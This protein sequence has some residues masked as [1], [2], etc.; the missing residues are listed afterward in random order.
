MTNM[1]MKNV[2]LIMYLVLKFCVDVS[3]TTLTLQHFAIVMDAQHALT[4]LLEICDVQM[5]HT[6]Q[7]HADSDYML[8]CAR[9]TIDESAS[10]RRRE[11]GDWGCAG[12]VLL[13]L[14]HL[15]QTM[16]SSRSLFQ[17]FHHLQL[18][19]HHRHLL[20]H[21]MSPTTITTSTP[22]TLTI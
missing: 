8:D 11:R 22:R 14:R 10:Q 21:M 3:S 2:N 7:R 18:Q 13:R 15:V 5:V 4:I 6:M 19:L 9:T 17:Q 16:G 20:F 1:A 12:L